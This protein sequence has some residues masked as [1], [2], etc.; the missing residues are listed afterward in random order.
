MVPVQSGF[1]VYVPENVSLAIA[2]FKLE[3]AAPL[4]TL[5]AESRVRMPTA[6]LGPTP[7]TVPLSVNPQVPAARLSEHG[8]PACAGAAALITRV[9]AKTN[10][11]PV[12]AKL[13]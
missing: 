13:Y 7:T 11:N 1:T 10:A 3:V 5:P 9:T 12:R 8:P 2:P 4:S 6:S